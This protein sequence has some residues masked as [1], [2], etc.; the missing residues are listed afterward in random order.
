MTTDKYYRQSIQFY[1]RDFVSHL[2]AK[3][4]EYLQD[5]MHREIPISD[6]EMQVVQEIFQNFQV[7]LF[8][9]TADYAQKRED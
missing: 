8:R 9:T 4:I 5:D 3:Y 1:M 6:T 7:W 2:I